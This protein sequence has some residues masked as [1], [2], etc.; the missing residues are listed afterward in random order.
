M[1]KKI[2][3]LLVEDILRDL[4]PREREEIER[5]FAETTFRRGEH[6]YTP[7]EEILF[8][9][10][11]GMVQLYRLTREGEKRVV[12]S[13]GPGT[14]FGEMPLIGQG[15]YGAFAQAVEDCTLGT[16]ERP[17]LERLLLQ[18]PTIA[19]RILEGVGKRLSE[20]ESLLED[21]TFKGVR[22]R[23]ASLLLRLM[24]E[25]GPVIA[26]YTHQALAD[27]IG[28]YRETTTQTLGLF[29]R[30]GLIRIGRKRL[31]IL[32]VEGLREIAEK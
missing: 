6:I 27:T 4:G 22:A 24:K 28:T 15:M 11:E 10:K 18:R 1:K 14:I 25:Q 8:L 12:D 30:Q 21:V 9:L 31:Q 19:L 7:E 16:M 2:G 3:Y 17:A 5:S 26:G 13:L 20:A 29:K 32:D 23:L